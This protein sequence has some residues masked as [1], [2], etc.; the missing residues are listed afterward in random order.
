MTAMLSVLVQVVAVICGVV[1]CF[2]HSFWRGVSTAVLV[3]ALHWVFD[4][5]IIGAYVGYRARKA[6]ERG[7]LFMAIGD[8]AITSEAFK[9]DCLFFATVVA[10]I[11]VA[12]SACFIFYQF[13]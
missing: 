10:W 4:V 1:Q 2:T 9:R 3:T 12:L 8:E 13:R 7:E 6:K 5:V 11:Y